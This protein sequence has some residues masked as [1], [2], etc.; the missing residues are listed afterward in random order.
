MENETSAAEDS[1]GA[2]SRAP[3]RG[4]EIPVSD[5]ARANN[6]ATRSAKSEPAPRRWWASHRRRASRKRT[7]RL[8]QTVRPPPRIP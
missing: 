8:G 2:Q 3:T 6:T 7:R 5:G 4:G 1:G